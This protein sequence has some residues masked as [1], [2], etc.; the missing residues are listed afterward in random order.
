MPGP[1]VAPCTQS[2]RRSSQGTGDAKCDRECALIMADVE[3]QVA[4]YHQLNVLIPRNE[5]LDANVF[6]RK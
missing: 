3:G 1:A 6:G 5:P 4:V 2:W